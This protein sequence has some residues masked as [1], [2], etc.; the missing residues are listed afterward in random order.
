MKAKN[1][2]CHLDNASTTTKLFELRKYF[3]RKSSFFRFGT[4]W[5]IFSIFFVKSIYFEEFPK[6]HCKIAFEIISKSFSF[7]NYSHISKLI[8]LL[9][10]C[11]NSLIFSLHIMQHYSIRLFNDTIL[12]FADDYDHL[13][14]RIPVSAFNSPYQKTTSPMKNDSSKAVYGI[15]HSN[16]HLKS[17]V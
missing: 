2:L 6:Y 8:L 17:F 1:L 10:F 5:N 16:N 14:F 4:A 3:F 12:L 9:Y 13:D 11:G 7:T 15:G